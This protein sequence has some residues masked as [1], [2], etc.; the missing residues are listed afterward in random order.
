M[1][2]ILNLNTND[3]VMREF[4]VRLRGYRLRQNRLQGEIARL[5]G[6]TPATVVNAEAGKNLRLES[7]VR[8]LRAL[9]QLE[10]LNDFLPE[11]TVSPIQLLALHGKVRQR[12]RKRSQ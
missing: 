7:I 2:I 6:V 10:A 4:G 3:E 12:A 11:P 5:A 8:I 1:T 9:G